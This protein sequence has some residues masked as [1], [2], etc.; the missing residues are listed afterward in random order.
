MKNTSEKTVGIFR[1]IPSSLAKKERSLAIKQN[2]S[3]DGI[4]TAAYGNF[5]KLSKVEQDILLALIPAKKM[6]RKV[7]A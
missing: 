4:A 2:K 3:L 5:F 7:K 1:T 6:G